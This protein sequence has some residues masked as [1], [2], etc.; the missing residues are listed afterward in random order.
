MVGWFL[1]LVRI[2]WHSVAIVLLVS[3]VATI[4]ILQFASLGYMLECAARVSRGQPWRNCF[5]GSKLAGKIMLVA[6]CAFITWLP[7]WFLADLAYTAE[8]IEPGANSARFL[9]IAARIA[10]A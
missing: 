2:A 10:A 5:P 4:P 6:L 3:V 8:I 1:F 7:I 9:R